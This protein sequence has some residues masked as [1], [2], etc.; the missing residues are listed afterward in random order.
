LIFT[1]LGLIVPRGVGEAKGKRVPYGSVENLLLLAKYFGASIRSK[2]MDT[3]S[4]SPRAVML[5]ALAT[6]NLTI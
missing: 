3:T 1:L 2:C 6:A 5:M 4:K